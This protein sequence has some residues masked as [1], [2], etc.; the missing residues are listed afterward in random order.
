MSKNVKVAYVVV[1]WNNMDLLEECFR[2]INSQTHKERVI[3]M[4]D[5]NSSDNSTKYIEENFPE[6]MIIKEAKNH[7]F[8]VA[9]NIGIKKALQDQHIEYLAL[10]N[11]DARLDPAW[12]SR[13]VDFAVLKPAGAGFQGTTL[14]YY[15]NSIIDSTH[16]F[17]ARNGQGTQGNWRRY[18]EG[19]LGPKKVFGVNAAAAIYSRKF[20]E[21]QP[22]QKLF[23]ES[24]FMYLEDVDVAAR[25]TVGGWD[26]FLVPHARAYHMGS[27]SSKK[28]SSDFSLY[29]TF[30]NNAAVLVKNIPFTLI[31]RMIPRIIRGD[32]DTIKHLRKTGRGKQGYVVIKARIV[33]IIRL[34]IYFFKHIITKK[35]IPKKYLWHLM[36]RGY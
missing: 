1:S 9:N 16:I 7:G 30:R 20:I 36:N 13:I 24:L 27:A 8:A 25:S 3:V 6:V 22:D 5:N 12:T 26:N 18:Y 15:D 2:S 21:D 35:K 17:I 32:V 33:G 29:Y 28:R 19:E 31:I 34:P 10:V 14:D 11:T 23:D 4:V